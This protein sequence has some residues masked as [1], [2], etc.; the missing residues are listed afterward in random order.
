MQGPFQES[1]LRQRSLLERRSLAERRALLLM[2]VGFAI[3]YLMN[4]FRRNEYKE[5]MLDSWKPSN[6]SVVNVKTLSPKNKRGKKRF[7]P[8][9]LICITNP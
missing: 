7:L 6:R 5:I 1:L 9:L 2:S 4:L 8:L 3:V